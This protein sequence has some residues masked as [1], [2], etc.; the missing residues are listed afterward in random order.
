MG[1]RRVHV[2]P[3]PG[4]RHRAA[5][6]RT[7]RSLYTLLDYAC[8]TTVTSI[9]DPLKHPYFTLTVGRVYCMSRQR[10]DPRISITG[11]GPWTCLYSAVSV[12][13]P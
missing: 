8:L 1:L 7:H 10:P 6:G 12:A 13:H 9:H 2:I 3:G 4:P 5:S 11:H